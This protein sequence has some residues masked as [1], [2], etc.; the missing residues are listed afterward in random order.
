MYTQLEIVESE[1]LKLTV[2]ERA[3]LAQRLLASLDENFEIEDAW[4]SEVKRRI[5][6]VESGDVQ[7]IPFDE[8]IAVLRAGLK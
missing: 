5:E 7:D 8:A 4:A 3:T 2:G 6:A 1:A